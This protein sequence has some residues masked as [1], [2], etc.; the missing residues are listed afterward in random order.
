MWCAAQVARLAGALVLAPVMDMA[1]VSLQSRLQ[2]RSKRSA[3]VVVIIGCLAAA[4]GAFGMTI[5]A[6][7]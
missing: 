1:S 2:L 7:A 6:W 3:L 4:I 5:L